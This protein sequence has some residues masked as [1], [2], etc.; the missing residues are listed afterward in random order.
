MHWQ[1]LVDQQFW[2]FGRDVAAEDGN[3]LLRLGAQRACPQCRGRSACYRLPIADGT[4]PD[5]RSV[6]VLLWGFGLVFCEG[7]QPRCTLRRA[8]GAVRIAADAAA[9]RPTLKPHELDAASG[10]RCDRW[11][12]SI[13]GWVAAYEREVVKRF[14]LEAR[15]ADVA[16]WEVAGKRTCPAATIAPRWESF[17]SLPAA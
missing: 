12:R 2:L 5:A 3:R 11:G 14:G 10:E 6:S 7:T 8:S 16:A 15:A 9:A 1:P 17:A 4:V 13:A